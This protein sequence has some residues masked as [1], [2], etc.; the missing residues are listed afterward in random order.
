M[1]AVDWKV[2]VEAGSWRA[3]LFVGE[4]EGGEEEAF[5]PVRVPQMD[6]LIVRDAAEWSV[7]MAQDYIISLRSLGEKEA[8]SR[9]ATLCWEPYSLS[10]LRG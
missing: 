8:L 2:E 3:S 1:K 5:L 6:M 10:N 4:A 7:V 9:G